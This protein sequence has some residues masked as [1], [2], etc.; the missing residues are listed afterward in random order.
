MDGDDTAELSF[1]GMTDSISDFPVFRSDLFMMGTEWE[2]CEQLGGLVLDKSTSSCFITGTSAE[3]TE[4]WSR[5]D[6]RQ[7]GSGDN[8]DDFEGE[9]GFGIDG[10]DNRTWEQV[11]WALEG[12]DPEPVLKSLICEFVIEGV[13]EDE[14][15]SGFR[16]LT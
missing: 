2:V 12:F 11:C 10:I 13:V 7:E 4:R 8:D 3:I 16:Y 1:S 14:V 9:I 5:D 6:F 15:W